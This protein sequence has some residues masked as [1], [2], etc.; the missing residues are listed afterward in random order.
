MSSAQSNLGSS[1]FWVPSRNTFP[2]FAGPSSESRNYAEHDLSSLY[3]ETFGFVSNSM[4]ASIVT[5]SANLDSRQMPWLGTQEFMTVDHLR[6]PGSGDPNDASSMYLPVFD[7]PSTC[8]SS[9]DLPDLPSTNRDVRTC[10]HCGTTSTTAW[11]RVTGYSESM[12][13]ACGL[14]LQQRNMSVFQTH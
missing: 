12:C 6:A 8:T 4:P 10:T 3:P 14:Y 11:R 13:N 7:L 2:D 5:S 9:I 1:K